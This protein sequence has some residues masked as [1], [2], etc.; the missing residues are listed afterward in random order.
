MN[1]L[2][3]K[4]D[5]AKEWILAKRSA[6]TCLDDDELEEY[7]FD[8]LI[9]ETL[10]SVDE[11]LLYCE[12]CQD[13]VEAETSF[14]SAFR[15]AAKQAEVDDLARAKS[16]TDEA[17]RGWGN[18]LGVG[19]GSV[20]SKGP[21]LAMAGVALVAAVTL[22]NPLTRRPG[23][24]TAVALSLARG[25]GDVAVSAPAGGALRLSADVKELPVLP[26][27]QVDVVN[28]TGELEQST[29][30][31]AAGGLLSW[32]LKDGLPGG[33]HWVRLR[34]PRDGSL[35]REFGLVVR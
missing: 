17:R 20:F 24:E 16:G 14:R 10:E 26:R 8:R 31:T 33:R 27:W 3:R 25:G 35:V 7:L 15:P 23:G 19:W 28:A 11:H 30:V 1:G 29:E 32:Q 21:M 34:D 9:G 4:D 18:F 2:S 13:R 6:E 22:Y 5:S 12:R